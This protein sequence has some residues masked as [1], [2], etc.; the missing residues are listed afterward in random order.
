[1]AQLIEEEKVSKTGPT[2]VVSQK[3]YLEDN[4]PVKYSIGEHRVD[5]KDV[6]D[7]NFRINF[8]SYNPVKEESL[9]QF[10]GSS[11]T[12]SHYVKLKRKGESWCHTII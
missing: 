4:F 8:W 7:N 11:I 6:G 12:R 10:R 9:M 2:R 3:Q 1:M 5:Y